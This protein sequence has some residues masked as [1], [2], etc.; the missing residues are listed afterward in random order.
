MSEDLVRKMEMILCISNRE[1][2][3]ELVTQVLEDRN[4]KNTEA[5]HK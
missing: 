1:N 2:Y 5:T 4:S 3:R